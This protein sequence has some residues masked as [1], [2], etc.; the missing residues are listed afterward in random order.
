MNL[1]R[2]K[3]E[4][5]GHSLFIDRKYLIPFDGLLDMK[6]RAKP[7]PVYCYGEI[8]GSATLTGKRLNVKVDKFGHKMTYMFKKSCVLGLFSG[9]TNVIM[10]Q[11]V[12]V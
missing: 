11:V 8:I 10:G 7:S 5:F 4:N 2:P 12:P 6:F 9:D 3:L 1:S